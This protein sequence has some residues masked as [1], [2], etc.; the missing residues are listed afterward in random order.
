MRHG[1]DFKI[2]QLA[3]GTHNNET[4]KWFE[5]LNE[6]TNPEEKESALKF[7]GKPCQCCGN[8]DP[9][10]GCMVRKCPFEK[11]EEK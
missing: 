7:D 9:L 11:K 2:E 4:P 6:K 5:I 10:F 3:L 8:N 1:K